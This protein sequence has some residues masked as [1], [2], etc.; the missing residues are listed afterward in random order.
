MDDLSVSVS[1][2][3]IGGRIGN[4]F[5]NHLCYVDDLCLGCSSFAGLQK[6]LNIYSMYASDHSLTYNAFLLCF[7]P[8][9]IQFGRHELYMDTLL[10][11]NVSECKKLGTIICQ[12]NCDPDINNNNNNISLLQTHCP[13]TYKKK[14]KHI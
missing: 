4:I 5:L 3:N 6:L 13:Y 14:V 2:S 12:K 9:T 1:S 7:I 11:P 8:G 10:V